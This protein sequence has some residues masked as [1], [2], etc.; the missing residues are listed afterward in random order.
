MHQTASLTEYPFVGRPF[1][2]SVLFFC[3]AVFFQLVVFLFLVLFL[4]FP[5][6]SRF[7]FLAVG[8][9]VNFSSLRLVLYVCPRVLFSFSFR[10]KLK[11]VVWPQLEEIL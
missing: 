7:F 11:P 3:G 2:L 10:G 6:R 1:S 9:G 4:P 8:G 5:V